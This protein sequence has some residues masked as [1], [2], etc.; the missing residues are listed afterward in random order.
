MLSFFVCLL[1]HSMWTGWLLLH[2]LHVQFMLSL[3]V[4]NTVDRL[5]RQCLTSI[6]PRHGVSCTSL[7]LKT[8]AI[9]LYISCLPPAIGLITYLLAAFVWSLPLPNDIGEISLF[10]FWL[11]I[12]FMARRFYGLLSTVLFSGT[13]RVLEM[14]VFLG[15]LT[16]PMIVS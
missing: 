14:I 11:N 1:G 5:L 3:D 6:Y 7:M 10:L 4:I 8:R 12:L 2:V 15:T 9:F 13:F 16:F